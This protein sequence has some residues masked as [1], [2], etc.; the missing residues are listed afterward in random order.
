MKEFIIGNGEKA[1]RLDQYLMRLMPGVGKAFLYKM[2]R[3]KNIVKNGKK[4]EGNERLVPGDKICIY[5][6]D[7]TYEKFRNVK[8]STE[9]IS[10]KTVSVI[11]KNVSDIRILYEDT[12]ILV[13][14]KP[15]GML[16][17]KAAP[18]D[19][20]LNDWLLTY[21]KQNGGAPWSV[22]N[23]LSVPDGLFFTPSV[24]NRLDRNTSGM[25]LCGKSLAGLRYL[26]EILRN[27]SLHKYYLAI[28]CGKV[29]KEQEIEGYL[30]KDEAAN[31]VRIV[32][33]SVNAANNGNKRSE[34]DYIA[35]F[36]RPIR[37]DEVSDTTLLEVLLKTGKP[38]QI[39]AHL[40]AISHP[41]AGDPK[42]G[43]PDRN[44]YF[45]Q[46]YHIKRQLLHCYKLVFPENPDSGMAI[47][48]KILFSEPPDDFRQI[49]G[50]NYG[51]LEF[52][53]S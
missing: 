10:V 13:A 19:Y 16:S 42:Y 22:T 4:A 34:G 31:Q 20:S 1:L 5:F 29:T 39:R 11:P 6:S 17:Q 43:N 41:I 45:N 32:M 26:A 49:T 3:K 40:A 33:A 24:A 36:Y 28:V 50:E 15:A 2:L 21:L 8:K 7:E 14:D 46:K 52:T 48:G 23:T 25:V 44:R 35:T 12:D 27:R 47:Q 30:Y 18:Q 53:R 51:N 37:Y 9:P 38:H